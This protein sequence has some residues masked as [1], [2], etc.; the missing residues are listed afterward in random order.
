MPADDL[1]RVMAEQVDQPVTVLVER[2]GGRIS[3]SG[4]AKQVELTIPANPLRRLGLQLKI[5]PIVSIRKG[6]PAAKAGFQPGDRLVA[7]NDEKIGDPMLLTD[8]LRP[9]IGKEVEFDVERKVDGKIQILPI[10]VRPEPEFEFA[11]AIS[12]GA[13]AAVDSIGVA[14]SIEPRVAHAEPN[15]PA[16]EAG[17]KAGDVLQ[18]AL[19]VITD[20]KK[21]EAA[22]KYLPNV[23]DEP[24]ELGMEHPNWTYVYGLMQQLPPTTTLKLTYTRGDTPFEATL[25]PRVDPNRFYHD[26]GLIL[27]EFQ[28]IYTAE[29]WRESWQLGMQETRESIMAV[30]FTLG[31][32]FTGQLAVSSLGGPVMIAAV[33]GSE[34]SQGVPRLLLFLTLLSANLAVLNFLPIPALDGGHILFL[35]AEAVIGKPVDERLQGTLT[36]IGI[37]ALLSLMIFVCFNDIGRLIP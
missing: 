28:R 23:F 18:S 25:T 24:I 11:T 16:A 37:V 33:A 10:T 35:S 20:K 5:G 36:L 21:K 1:L 12:P 34:A 8:R 29:S 7:M 32:L 2:P 4:T 14:Y 6:S 31:K 19:F 3:E 17:L 13:L 26:R 9:L 30:F 22:L 27:T 15:L